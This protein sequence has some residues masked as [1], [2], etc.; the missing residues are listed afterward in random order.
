MASYKIPEETVE[1]VRSQSDIVQVISEYLTLKKAG[2]NYKACCPF[3]S[4]KTPSFI[5]SP[6]KQMFYCFGCGAGGNV[7][8]FLMRQ[9]GFAFA[10]AVKHLAGRLGIE[11]KESGFVPEQQRVREQLFDLCE[12]ARGYYTRRLLKSAEAAHARSY[13]ER[14]RLLGE[15]VERFALGYAPAGWDTFTSE[16]SKK[17]FS[18]ELLLQGGMA[19]KNPE[20]RVYDTFR[21]RVM[22]PILDLMGKAIAFGGRALEE[23]QPKYINSPETPIYRKG[24]T[25][26]N[27]HQAKRSSLNKNSVFVV[28]GYVDAI[29]LA[30]C[31]FDNVVASLGTAFTQ[32]QARLLKR[33]TSQVTLVFDSDIAGE[34]AAGRG[35]EV[36]LEQGL[37]VR[38]LAFSGSKDPDE[39]LLDQGAEAFQRCADASR[40]FVEYHIEN[41]QSGREG[42]D[43]DTKVKTANTLASLVARIPDPI[44][45]EEYL[46]LIAGRVG[47]QPETLLK[48]SQKNDFADKIIIEV[49]QNEKR[50]KH[51]EQQCLWLIK[52][53]AERPECRGIIKEN[54]DLS[55]IDNEALRELLSASFQC[56][57][58]NVLES[59]LLDAVQ[60]EDAQRF[61]SRL[62]FEEAGPE[63]LYPVEW[64]LTII[65]NRQNE[66]RLSA[67]SAEIGEAER[68]GDIER[69]NQLAAQKMMA[70][71]EVEKTKKELAGISVYLEGRQEEGDLPSL[72]AEIRPRELAR[73]EKAGDHAAA[74]AWKEF[75]ESKQKKGGDSGRAERE[76]P[77]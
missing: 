43:I 50:L 38:V 6:H 15:A 47:I 7:F 24:E 32:S 58:G 1:A 11:I 27:L 5:V 25:L 33:Y 59:S 28:E 55:T 74:R 61:L 34:A 72:V 21:N 57:D 3:H 73:A 39:F 52:L 67:L 66:K 23:N 4:E 10:E 12:F 36:L 30:L 37:D 56:K 8:G 75:L 26:Y 71:R 9:E 13:L 63:L 44:K 53:L 41:A 42:W 20:G 64:W 14:R 60:N 2:S 48:A 40:N 70:R 31:G 49:K 29:R 16:A 35:I 65:K 54:L 46:R 19:K 18:P 76:V 68:A 45:K 77:F 22:F 69:F 51:D 17:G 62:S